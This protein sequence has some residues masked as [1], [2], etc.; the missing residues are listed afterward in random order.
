M[1][2]V[3]RFGHA[4]SSPGYS[5][6]AHEAPPSLLLASEGKRVISY[7]QNL[8]DVMIARLFPPG[9][10]GFY[11][12]VGA[13][14][15]SYL[16]VTRHFYDAG[17]RGVNVEP[18][19]RFFHRLQHA[20]PLDINLNAVIGDGGGRRTFYEI[21]ELP[22]NSTSD[23]DVLAQLKAQGRTA[24]THEVDVISLRDVCER[25][26]AGREIDFMKI[27]VEGGELEVIRSADWR[28][29]RPVLLVIEAVVVNG[30]EQTWAT[31]EPD[32]LGNGY[33]KVW[34]DGLNNF[35]LRSENLALKEHFRLPPNVF[36]DF[37]EAR[38]QSAGDDWVDIGEMLKRVDADRHAKQDVINGVL[39]ELAQ[40]D[41]DRHAKQEVVDR[42]V[43]ELALVDGDRHAKQEVIDRL[44]SERASLHADRQAQQQHIEQLTARLASLE[45]VVAAAKA[46]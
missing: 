25:F 22:E 46:P 2:A 45:G 28:R 40:V 3:S 33:E 9:H 21:A 13:A 41:A 24:R 17:W 29:F 43:A 19:P 34:F 35:Y 36:D 31:W 7:A 27:D 42:V 38:L 39:A 12:D 23:E 8:E 30:R 14:D 44:L 11:I 16:S 37:V 5:F 32:I 10:A 6:K 26:A 15:P 20:R 18:L 1:L 4:L